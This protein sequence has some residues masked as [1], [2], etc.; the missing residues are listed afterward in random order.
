MPAEEQAVFENFGAEERVSDARQALYADAMRGAAFAELGGFKQGHQTRYLDERLFLDKG[1]A[2]VPDAFDAALNGANFW[3]GIDDDVALYRLEAVSFALGGSGV[4]DLQDLKTAIDRRTSNDPDERDAARLVLQRVTDQ[5]NGRRDRRPSFATTEDEIKPLLTDSGDDWAN[6][7]R[8]HLGLG[9][10][11]PQPGRV[12]AVLLLRYTVR[13]VR[14]CK[15]AGGS[16]FCIPTVLDG[17]V[18]PYFFPTPRPGAS[19]PGSDRQVGRAVNLAATSESDYAMRLELVHS[20]VDYRP[21]HLVRWGLISR[22]VSADLAQLRGFHLSW[23]RL[24]TER[25]T[26]GCD[27]IHV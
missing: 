22:P 21:D 25:D 6:A 14:R 9:H 24:E 5:W 4:D 10:F 2:E 1:V 15:A 18:N 26:F 20:Y 3:P 13:E 16:A 8:D 17:N 7:A 27:L 12:E 19:A 23:L 11:N